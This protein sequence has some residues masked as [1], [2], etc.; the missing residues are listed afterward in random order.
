[1]KKVYFSIHS[2][3]FCTLLV[4]SFFLSVMACGAVQRHTQETVPHTPAAKKVSPFG[5]HAVGMPF[6]K[7]VHGL[8][9]S[10]VRVIISGPAWDM[11]E[12]NAGIN[13]KKLD[14]IVNN[15]Q[16]GG[17]DVVFTLMPNSKRWGAKRLFEKK[18]KSKI[19]PTTHA[20][21]PSKF[22]KYSEVIRAIVERY[23]NDGIGDMPGLA[24][25]VDY[26]QPVNE[27]VWQWDESKE[28]YLKYLK[29]TGHIIKKAHPGARIILG[30]LTGVEFLAVSENIDKNRDLKL[31]GMFGLKQPKII[32]FSMLMSKKGA[33]ITK[34]MERIKYIL[35]NGRAYYDIVDFHSY[36]EN[37]KEMIPAI[38]TIKRFAPHKEIWSLE[39]AGPFYNYSTE[40]QC[41]EMIKRN[42]AGLHYGV[43]K[44]FW[45][46]FNVTPGWS[47]NYLNLSLLTRR[48][49]KKPAY[50]VYKFLASNLNDLRSV[51]KMDLGSGVEAYEIKK[52][53]GPIYVIWSEKG[54]KTVKVPIKGKIKEVRSI[55]LKPLRSKIKEIEKQVPVQGKHAKI[56]VAGRPIF[57]FP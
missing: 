6:V 39:N 16:A 1:M 56:Q 22:N 47:K 23:D 5:I 3:C 50:F 34:Q 36:T 57:L 48:G 43:K 9:C 15:L 49:G 44:T 33:D 42:I 4:F 25:S 31:G 41:R 37:Y 29:D 55:T 38:K 30:G 7:E 26:Y 17:L 11:I 14:H 28:K 27:W 19:D 18:K 32:P 46:S 54:K 2:L 13:F 53:S 40:K 24:Y 45:S 35:R 10:I 51:R 20:A 8:G 21:Y 12:D 52:D